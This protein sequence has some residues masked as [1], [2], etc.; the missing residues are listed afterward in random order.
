M[1]LDLGFPVN[2]T[3]TRRVV[4]EIIAFAPEGHFTGDDAAIR[5]STSAR[6]LSIIAAQCGIPFLKR[7]RDFVDP[8]LLEIFDP[9]LLNRGL[10]VP[11]ARDRTRFYFAVVNPWDTTG[12]DA[13]S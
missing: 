6:I 7:I 8:V 1:N 5:A 2:E 12:E 11:I 10:F 9:A 4:D 13:I 3:I